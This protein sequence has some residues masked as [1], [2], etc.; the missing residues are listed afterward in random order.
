MTD[1]GVTGI[2]SSETNAQKH[3]N[4][5][6]ELIP[7]EETF[8]DFEAVYQNL[9]TAV[10]KAKDGYIKHTKCLCG[11]TAKISEIFS[12]SYLHLHQ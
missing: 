2:P 12:D 3:W 4:Q 8:L 9:Q 1:G 10:D 11:D 6:F 5:I 7:D